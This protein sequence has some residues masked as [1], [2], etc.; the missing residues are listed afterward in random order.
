MEN[1]KL[2]VQKLNLKKQ[3][4][5][6][7]QKLFNLDIS[8]YPKL[9]KVDEGLKALTPMYDFFAKMKEKR[10]SWAKKPWDKIEYKELEEGKKFFQANMRELKEKYSDT[11]VYKRLKERVDE[12]KSSLPLIRTLKE[13]PF[14]KVEHWKRLLDLID[15][16]NT[17]INFTSITLEQVFNMN[18]QDY[19]NEVGEIVN[20]AKNEYNNKQELNAIKEYWKQAELTI[21]DFRKG[22]KIKVS[23]DIKQDLDN[24]LNDLQ[25]IEGNKFAGT[26]L[27]NEVRQWMKSLSVIQECLEVWIAVQTKWLYLEGIY[28]GNEDIRLQLPKATTTFEQHD[29][30]FRKINEGAS[31]APNVYANCVLNDTTKTQLKNLSTSLDIS[32]KKLKDY[33]ESKKKEF[34]RFYFISDEDLL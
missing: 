32:Q 7:N 25:G 9:V 33:L 28:I 3:D 10:E 5:V 26:A 14:F 6:L 16:D 2:Q 12:F 34:P 4:L 22:C 31:K 18:L 11:Q 23:E 13:N 20:A 24:H 8:S 30:N 21:V 27:K 29:K 1:Y 19:P 15:Q 17:N